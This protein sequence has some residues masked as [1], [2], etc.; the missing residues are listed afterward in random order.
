[1]SAVRGSSITTDIPQR[2]DRLPWSRLEDALKRQQRAKARFL[3][4]PIPKLP[5][6]N[7]RL[8]QRIGL[9]AHQAIA[10]EMSRYL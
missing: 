5:L 8:R 10:D 4:E 2:M 7:R 9:D 3:T 1:M 6:E